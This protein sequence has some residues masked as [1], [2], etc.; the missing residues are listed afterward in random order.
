MAIAVLRTLQGMDPYKE[1]DKPPQTNEDDS[2]PGSDGKRA[3]VENAFI[4]EQ[5]RDLDG[6]Q[7]EL[8][9]ETEGQNA[10]RRSL[11]AS[12]HKVDFVFPDACDTGKDPYI[13]A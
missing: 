7:T 10:L 5:N 6:H 13:D 9:N 1:E 2:D 4:E 12:V 3:R 8:Q 11:D